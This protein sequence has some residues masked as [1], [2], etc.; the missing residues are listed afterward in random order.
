MLIIISVLLTK[1]IIEIN[2]VSCEVDY[3]KLSASSREV[4]IYIAGY[5]AIKQRND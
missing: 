4:A 3:V 5:V 2:N 1:L